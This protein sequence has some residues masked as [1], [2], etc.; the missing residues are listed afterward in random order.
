MSFQTT[1]TS[2]PDRTRHI[3]QEGR[4][5]EEHKCVL[6]GAVTQQPPDDEDTEYIPE[7][8]EKLTPEER[9]LCPF[10]EAAVE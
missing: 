5:R 2:N 9:A 7:R 3:W 1:K 8:Y 10:K 6:C 4:F